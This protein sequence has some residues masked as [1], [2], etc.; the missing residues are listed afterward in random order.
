MSTK[1]KYPLLEVNLSHLKNNANTIV[2]FCKKQGISTAG[3]I[4]FSDGDINI[5]RAFYEGGCKQIASSR[6][7]HLKNIK[8]KLPEAETVLIR[9]P[10]LSEIPDVIKYCDISLNS[11]R[12]TLIALNEEAKKANKKH[13]VILLLDVGDLREG[14][15]NTDEFFG[16][17]TFTEY[18]LKN[19]YLA[20]VGSTFACFGSIL[21]SN[22]NLG[23]LLDAASRIENAIDRKLEI[24]SG[25]SSVSLIIM[26]KEGI[27]KGINHLRIGTAI[28]NPKSLRL[29]RGIDIPGTCDDTFILSAQII[30]VGTKPTLPFGQKSLNWSGNKIEFEDRGLRKR[31]IL[32][33]GSQ[34]VGDA[35]KLF[36][37]DE[38]VMVIGC[39]SD[40]TIIDI[41]ES[42][43]NWKVGDIVSFNLSYMPL[44]YSFCTRHVQIKYI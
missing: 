32:A 39:S 35:K 25:G 1:Q 6:S 12:D 22:E 11:E 10:M 42:N 16:L 23:T 26:Q 33:L 31:A 13:K 15:I 43:K 38:G 44:M 2:E 21:P 20:G 30:E 9:L 37:I 28:A 34:D 19:L 17:A 4:K 40:H 27:P 36:P 41:E 24:I 3:V 8:N 29:N 18:K 7:I 5:A 14:M